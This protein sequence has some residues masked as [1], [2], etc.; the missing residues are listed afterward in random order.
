M[1][2]FFKKYSFYEFSML[3]EGKEKKNPTNKP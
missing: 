1:N 2:A 3:T